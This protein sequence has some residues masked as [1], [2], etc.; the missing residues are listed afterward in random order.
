M[1][2]L[3]ELIKKVPNMEQAPGDTSF[4]GGSDGNKPWVIK[5][6]SEYVW[7]FP[8]DTFNRMENYARTQDSNPCKSLDLH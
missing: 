4:L 3:Q 2:L 1:Y 6:G 8:N 7:S 5:K